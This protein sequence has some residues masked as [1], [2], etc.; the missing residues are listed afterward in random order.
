MLFV[1]NLFPGRYRRNKFFRLTPG[2][3]NRLRQ[4]IFYLAFHLH[5]PWSEIMKLTVDERR[6]FVRMLA[7]R[8]EEDNRAWENLYRLRKG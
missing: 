7:D 5:W 1:Q 6:A 8:I 2:G 3:G 4:E